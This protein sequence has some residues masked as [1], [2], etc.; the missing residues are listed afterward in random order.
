MKEDSTYQF[1]IL[2]VD[3]EPDILLALKIVLESNGFRTEA[4]GDPILALRSF[5]AGSYD[6][7]LLDIRM[8][9]ITG[10]GL[11]K[12]LKKIDNKIRVC[13]LSAIS[14]YQEFAKYF[15]TI[16]EN[17]IIVKPVDNQT[18]IQRINKIMS[19]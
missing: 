2:V 14:N 5:I 17:Q 11:Y 6:L 15:P 4:F 7:A 10:L 19:L 3:D 16:N 1:R 8:P 9:R 18:L 13:F 12:E